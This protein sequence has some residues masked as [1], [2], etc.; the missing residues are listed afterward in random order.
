[1]GKSRGWVAMLESGERRATREDVSK[2]Q[3]VLQL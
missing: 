2:L 1:M 3:R